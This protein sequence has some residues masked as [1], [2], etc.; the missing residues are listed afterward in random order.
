LSV[1]HEGHEEK[2]EGHEERRNY[3]KGGELL[4]NAANYFNLKG[5]AA[6]RC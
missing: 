5:V 1:G 3:K 6:E 2:A 4:S